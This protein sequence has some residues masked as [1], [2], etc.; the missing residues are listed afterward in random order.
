MASP[1]SPSPTPP[2]SPSSAPTD[3][4]PGA[5]PRAESPLLRATDL[6][7][8]Y[9]SRSGFRTRE[10]HVLNGVSFELFPGRFTAL[11]GE[12]GSGK[13]TVARVLL[14]LDALDGGS[15][16]LLGTQR[17]VPGASPNLDYR[18]RVQL[19]FQDPF[20]SLN[21]VHPVRHA[22]VRPL[23]RHLPQLSASELELRATELL[24]A[25][26]LAPGRV[27]LGKYPHE[28]SGGQRQ[29][30]AIARA[31]APRPSI[32]VADE[33]TSML[34]VSIRMGILELLLDSKQRHA[35]GG[36]YITHDLASARYL[37]DWILV[38]FA[39]RIVE[40][41]PT[42]QLIQHPAHPYTRLLLDSAPD[43]R[44]KLTT[45]PPRGSRIISSAETSE[46]GCPF[47]SRCP[48]AQLVCRQVPPKRSAAGAEHWVR[49]H[50]HP[51]PP[52]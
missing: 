34:D 21:P 51:L 45:L 7:K 29:R 40:Q 48:E 15:V 16:E 31:L 44:T 4:P 33:P 24:E 46:T 22:L 17:L 20:A 18:R 1:T 41:G 37:A 10:H 3:L 49:C 35:L 9:R 38:L 32:L 13:S 12:S 19:V 43:A 27:F 23:R 6:Q 26:G 50:A 14:G 5:P 28:L 8:I 25:V 42:E 52:R 30:V 11:V 36:L 39:G 47:A 2:G